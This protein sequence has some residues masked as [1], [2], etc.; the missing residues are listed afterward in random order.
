MFIQLMN[1]KVVAAI[2]L[3]LDI[4]TR[5]ILK[6]FHCPSLCICFFVPGNCC[7]L[8]LSRIFTHMEM[9]HCL[10]SP[11][12][13]YL[14]S[15]SLFREGSVACYNYYDTSLRFLWSHPSLAPFIWRGCSTTEPACEWNKTQVYTLFKF[16]WNSLFHMS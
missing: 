15:A 1:W 5:P 13:L 7:L 14:C 8:S 4:L 11:S 6:Y 2:F 16:R 3:P 10:W 9:P 12:N